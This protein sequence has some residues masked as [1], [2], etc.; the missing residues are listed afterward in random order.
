MPTAS[1][2]I[3]YKELIRTAGI[4]GRFFLGAL[5][6]VRAPAKKNFSRCP[7]PHHPAAARSKTAGAR[8][9]HRCGAPSAQRGW[10]PNL[11]K[12]SE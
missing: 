10:S 4:A 1:P 12:L 9:L 8:R 3:E 2:A 7:K 11:I 5:V 6:R